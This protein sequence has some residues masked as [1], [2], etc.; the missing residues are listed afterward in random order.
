MNSKILLAFALATLTSCASTVSRRDPTGETFPRVQGSSLA[1]TTYTIPD[2]FAGSPVVLLLGFVMN[3][4]F[5]IDRWL[6]GLAQAGLEVRVHEVPTIE[7]LVP[8]MFAG[9]IDAG[10]R[11]GIPQEDWGSVIT[12]YGD[13][14]KI[15]ALTGNEAPRNGRVLLL[16]AAGKI[17]FFHDRGY[18]AGS[19]LRL[20]DAIQSR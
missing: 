8:G 20:K 1:G 15:V 7:G 11:S 2:D 17:V 3:A 13:A 10:M 4:Q 18:S 5:D 9:T 19:L 12:V 6:L 16:D 14:D